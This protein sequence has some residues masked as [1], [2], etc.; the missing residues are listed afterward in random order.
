MISSPGPSKSGKSFTIF[1]DLKENKLHGLVPRSCWYFSRSLFHSSQ[2]YF[3]SYFQRQIESIHR[4]L[5]LHGTSRGKFAGPIE[6]DCC[7][8]NNGKSQ[9]LEHILR[10][11]I[12]GEGTYQG[13]TKWFLQINARSVLHKFTCSIIPGAEELLGRVEDA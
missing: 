6:S 3:R 13:F 8:K 5:F 11:W 1:G 2:G 9:R 10:S 12:D 4:Q 7:L